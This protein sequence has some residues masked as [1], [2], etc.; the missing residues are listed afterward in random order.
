MALVTLWAGEAEEAMKL[1][2]PLLA[3]GDERVATA[4][5]DAAAISP[6]LDAAAHRKSVTDIFE[7]SAKL[8][9]TNEKR[10][11]LAWVL[12]RVGEKEKGVAILQTVLAS[13]PTANDVRLE[14]AQGLDDM[15]K[16]DEAAE[17]YRILLDPRL[18]PKT[19]P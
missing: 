11:Q 4:Y 19:K 10:R 13:D 7:R 14:L 17:H 6:K 1:L 8:T 9:L 5:L 16:K 3:K 12:R 15:G 2:Q 18:I